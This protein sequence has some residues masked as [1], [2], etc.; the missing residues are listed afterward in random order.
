[1]TYLESL[2]ETVASVELE[3]TSFLKYAAILCAGLLVLGF[4]GRLLFG[5]R[6]DLNHALSSTVGILAVYILGIFLYGTSAALSG[7]LASLP[8]VAVQDGMLALFAFQSASWTDISAVLVRMIVLAFL[9]NLVDTLLP[10][11]KNF[12]VWLL[13]RLATVFFAVLF[14]GII[15]WL[16][17]TYLPET[18][19]SL[20]PMILL[21]ILVAM[22]L[23]GALKLLVGIALATVNPII[24]ALYTFFFSSLVGRQLSKAVLTTLLLSALVFAL[25]H[26]GYV[27][28]S[29]AALSITTLLLLVL[30]LLALWYLINQI[31]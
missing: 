5:K 18:F 23:L 1:M 15:V 26:F 22:L 11:G 12:F 19:L 29:L 28:I 27:V 20:A 10:K 17:G 31:L 9:V 3:T 25:T 21:G 7:L 24:G 4:L 30:I 2:F 14:Q 6:S 13:L 16:S 8:F